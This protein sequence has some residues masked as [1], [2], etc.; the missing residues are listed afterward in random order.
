MERGPEVQTGQ[1]RVQ[2]ALSAERL[3]LEF[4]LGQA[5]IN[6]KMSLV[7]SVT[8]GNTF[9]LETAEIGKKQTKTGQKPLENPRGCLI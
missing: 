9:G 7:I 3:R 4:I 8:A 1:R 6:L 5:R 2:V